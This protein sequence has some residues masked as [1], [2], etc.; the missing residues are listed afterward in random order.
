MSLD[1]LVAQLNSKK[2]CSSKTPKLFGRLKFPSSKSLLL[3]KSM[4]ADNEA[5]GYFDGSS[6]YNCNDFEDNT[7]KTLTTSPFWYACRYPC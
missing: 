4:D 6:V 7:A 5:V 2:L 1:E 3:D